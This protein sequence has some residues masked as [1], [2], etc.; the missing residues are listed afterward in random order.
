MSTF[1]NS[2]RFA[3]LATRDLQQLAT[4]LQKLKEYVL[5]SDGKGQYQGHILA[6]V[7]GLRI[8]AKLIY[9]VRKCLSTAGCAVSWGHIVDPT[10]QACSAECDV[11]IH[12]PGHL[13]KWNEG[14]GPIMEFLFVESI[15]VK[16]VVS[17]KSQLKSIDTDYPK[18]LAQFGIV[19]VLLFAE[20]CSLTNYENLRAQAIECGYLGLWC[21]YF[22]SGELDEFTID[23]KHHFEF[24]TVLREVFMV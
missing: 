8:S 21:A 7:K 4:E 24:W 22:T 3:Y 11:I 1:S 10:G 14:D 18:Q 13:D 12:A 15:H 20:S 19:K 2:S 9:F 23:E 5:T 17:C 16:G 6:F